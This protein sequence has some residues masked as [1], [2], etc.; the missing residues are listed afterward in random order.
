MDHGSIRGARARCAAAVVLAGIL[1]AGCGGEDDEASTAEATPPAA[2]PDPSPSPAPPTTDPTPDPD[3]AP[4]APTD[5]PP[6]IS[7]TPRSQAVVGQLYDF[8]P[9]A[10]DPDGDALSFSI[11]NRPDW[12]SFDP[13]TGRLSGTPGAG[14]LGA[15]ENITIQVAANGRYDTLPPFDIEVVAVGTRSVTLTWLPPTENEDGSELTDLAGYKIRYGQASG[16]YTED[17]VLEDPGLSSYVVEGLAPGTY[18][19][20]VAAFNSEG[21]YSRNS[22]EASA[23]L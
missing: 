10:T 6:Q 15:Y 19:F 11:A 3:P 17:I 1:L 22:N 18:Y 13:K 14:D 4:P 12:L 16:T 21:V 5:S 9:T 23:T 2:A 20:V 7:G 8:R